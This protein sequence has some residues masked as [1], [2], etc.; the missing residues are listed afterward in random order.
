[1]IN[2]TLF[3]KNSEGNVEVDLTSNLVTPLQITEQL[4]VSLDSGEINYLIKEQQADGLRE[5]LAIYELSVNENY[6]DIL[7]HFVGI[8]SRALLRNETASNGIYA[9]RVMLTEAAKLLQGVLIDGV[10]VTQPENVD[11]RKTLK[12]VVE[13]LLK[14]A[15]F[16][17][18]QSPFGRFSLTADQNVIDVLSS[19]KSPQFKWNTQSTLWECLEQIGA[20][21][22]AIPTLWYGYNDADQLAFQ[23]SFEFVNA[24]GNEATAIIDKYANVDGE[25]VEETMY[26]TALGT[27]VENLR[28]EE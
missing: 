25:N 4:D 18:S 26:N 10:A 5:P 2:V 17:D 28:E 9:H 11:D 21:I 23:V 15:Q 8:D 24:T 13:R 19:V 20:V 1:M 27:V 6:A 16:D 7:Q 3:E 12:E 14:I 22:D